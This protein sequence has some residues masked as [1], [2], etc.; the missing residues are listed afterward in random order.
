MA[1]Q[2]LRWDEPFRRVVYVALANEPAIHRRLCALLTLLGFPAREVQKIDFPVEDVPDEAVFLK[3]GTSVAHII[4]GSER[5][6]V[7]FTGINGKKIRR[8][9]LTIA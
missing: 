9:V 5:L 4:S 3:H 1:L 6:H 7:I 8:A 2:I